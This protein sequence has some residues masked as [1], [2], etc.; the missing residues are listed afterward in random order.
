MN[1]YG[2]GVDTILLC[3]LADLELYKK[4]GGAKSVPPALK[5]FVDAYR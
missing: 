2:M 5:E 3:Y 4:E 1:V